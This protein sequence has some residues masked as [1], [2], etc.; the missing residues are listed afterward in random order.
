MPNWNRRLFHLV[1]VLGIFAINN[2][3]I[4]EQEK[5][6]SS[7]L[8]ART[9]FVQL[10]EWRWQD[11]AIECE[12]FL[13]PAGFS[14][15]QI[16][17]PNEHLDHRTIGNILPQFKG[18]YPWWVRYQP[19]SFQ[20]Y[21]RSGN[22][23]AFKDMLERCNAAG[24][25]V[26]ADIV[27]NHM[28]NLGDIGVAGTT[29]DRKRKLYA[30]YRPENFHDDC[31]IQ[32][33]DYSWSDNPTVRK[34]RAYSI[35]HCQL[36]DL[37]DLK[38]STKNVQ[39]NINNYI[40]LLIQLGVSGFR[41]DAAKHMQPDD[42]QRILEN[43]EKNIY[44]FQEVIDSGDQPVS[45]NDYLSTADATE[46]RYSYDI[47]NIFIDGKLA[48]LA[49]FDE[50]RGFIASDKAVV[51]ID[52]HDNQRGH[53]MAAKLNHREGKLYD[54]ANIFMLAWPYGY[55]K[56]MS[57]YEW[58]GVNDSLGPPHDGKGNTLPVHNTDGTINC[59]QEQWLCEHRRQTIANMVNFRNMMTQQ[60]AKKVVHWWD[61]E[62]NKIAFGL[63]AKDADYSSGFLVINKESSVLKEYLNTG[64]PAGKYCNV[65]NR[66]LLTISQ[67]THPEIVVD[68]NGKARINIKENSALA[69]HTSYMIEG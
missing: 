3:T 7:E 5:T 37:P 67:C 34:Q 45:I 13:G 49:N 25:A 2:N 43:L 23:E 55:P 61:N 28:A 69:I 19:V 41:I 30:H 68:E 38:T 20:L 33:S 65:I 44:I 50:R 62:R 56:V 16:S 27:I 42:I 46:F 29:F 39:H 52:N 21:S 35:R 57:S 18:I 11:I 53:G 58:G 15:V 31:V 10:F 8:S 24:V 36:G 66:P 22:P 54:L 1:I 47:G 17:P 48:D 59:F 26:Y 9:A 40:Q 6:T 32:Q 64:L 60:S 4:A 51:F 63:A 14:A 12:Q